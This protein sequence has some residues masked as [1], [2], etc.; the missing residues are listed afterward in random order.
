MVSYVEYATQ[1]GMWSFYAGW[2]LYLVAA[3]VAWLTSRPLSLHVY[4][5]IAIVGYLLCCMHVQGHVAKV[6]ASITS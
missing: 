1:L 3:T 4:I 2:F 6:A 5:A